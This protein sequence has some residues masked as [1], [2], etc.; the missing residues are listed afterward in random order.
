[1]KRINLVYRSHQFWALFVG[2]WPFAITVNSAVRAPQWQLD[3]WWRLLPIGSIMLVPWLVARSFKCL[4]FNPANQWLAMLKAVFVS[5]LFS[6]IASTIAGLQLAQPAQG[7]IWN[8]PLSDWGT[9]IFTEYENRLS[10]TTFV[11][12]YGAMIF[13][14]ASIVLGSAFGLCLNLMSKKREERQTPSLK[15]L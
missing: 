3:Q 4:S 8:E 10:T 2:F 5:L 13:V 9:V 1:M 14:P 6:L 12:F 15:Q 11:L 7:T